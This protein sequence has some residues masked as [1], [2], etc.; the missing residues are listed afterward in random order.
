M[1]I[2][3][4]IK[5]SDIANHIN[6]GPTD[7]KNLEKSGSNIVVRE[8][9]GNF[10]SQC[11]VRDFVFN[12]DFHENLLLFWSNLD[13]FCQVIHQYEI[14]CMCEF[15][16]IILLFSS[17]RATS[18]EFKIQ[19]SYHME[20]IISDTRIRLIYLDTIIS[21]VIFNNARPVCMKL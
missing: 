4:Y 8:K 1:N 3:I 14:K 7:L 16:R 2:Y 20:C 18:V 10:E 13:N 17:L 9:S 5:S 11:K 15:S 12:A 19:Y 21:L 6:R